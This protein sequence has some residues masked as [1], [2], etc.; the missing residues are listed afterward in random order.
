MMDVLDL[1]HRVGQSHPTQIEAFERAMSPRLAVEH[2]LWRM[3]FGGLSVAHVGVAIAGAD[4]EAH[5][6]ALDLDMVWC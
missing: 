6:R 5:R 3:R 2:V 4:R 1:Q